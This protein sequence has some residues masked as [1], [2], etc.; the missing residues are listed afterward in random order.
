MTQ[1]IHWWKVCTPETF[2]PGTKATWFNYLSDI[3]Q[4]ELS[5]K[6]IKENLLAHFATKERFSILSRMICS[7]IQP[8]YVSI[9]CIEKFEDDT[10]PS[11]EGTAGEG[12]CLEGISQ[13]YLSDKPTALGAEPH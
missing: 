12:H 9:I 10:K 7:T 5:S 3:I 4:L 6:N 8:K 13:G 11:L 2:L 1:N